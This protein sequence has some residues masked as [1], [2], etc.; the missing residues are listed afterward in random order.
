MDEERFVAILRF[1][2][3]V[4]GPDET[5]VRVLDA[6]DCLSFRMTIL[7]ASKLRDECPEF[8]RPGKLAHWKLVN[9]FVVF[10]KDVLD[11]AKTALLSPE[12]PERIRTAYQQSFEAIP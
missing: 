7:Y 8:D 9:D 2:Y 12:N 5:F 1:G 3:I 11:D 10:D 6:T 4:S